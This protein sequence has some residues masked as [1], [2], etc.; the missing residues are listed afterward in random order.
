MW[1][2]FSWAVFGMVALA[3][4]AP[5]V[6]VI[7][8]GCG[9][10]AG[11]QALVV[12]PRTGDV[13]TVGMEG[14]A[15]R[16]GSLSSLDLQRVRV[17]Y[18]KEAFAHSA[19]DRFVVRDGRNLH[20][21]D[22]T[23]YRRLAKHSVKALK[24]LSV[25]KW[26]WIDGGEDVIAVGAVYKSGPFGLGGS[27]G[28]PS[29]VR[30]NLSTG[31][32]SLIPLD[33]AELRA[34][35]FDHA[36]SRVAVCFAD[37]RVEVRSTVDGRVVGGHTLHKEIPWNTMGLAFHPEGQ[38]LGSCDGSELVLYDLESGQPTRRIKGVTGGKFLHFVLGGRYLIAGDTNRIGFYD[39][40]G[41]RLEQWSAPETEGFEDG[42]MVLHVAE[43]LLKVFTLGSKLACWHTFLA[44]QKAADAK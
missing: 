4:A 35:T 5:A 11:G 40:S 3:L 30:V 28:K 26:H 6:A 9:L 8:G 10:A 32:E 37:A 2:S 39:I 21:F 44:W 36:G 16:V 33:M 7:T 1:R 25:M 17:P 27:S 34:A 42:F 23:S 15:V 24:D 18:A 43:E 20:V 31:A 19:G 14:I 29:V 12:N 41:R 22:F 38:L 13:V